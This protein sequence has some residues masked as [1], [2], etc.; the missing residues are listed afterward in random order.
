VQDA[1]VNFTTGTATVLRDELQDA[2]QCVK[3]IESVGYGVV[4]DS[5]TFIPEDGDIAALPLEDIPGVLEVRNVPNGQQVVCFVP[6]LVGRER[7]VDIGRAAGYTATRDQRPRDAHAE[8]YVHAR[9]RFVWATALSLPV[10][11]ISMVPGLGFTGR[12]MLLCALTTP[13][14]VWAGRDFFVLAEKALRHAAAD[15]NTL[16]ALG[17]GA[18]YLYSLVATFVPSWIMQSGMAPEVYFEAAAVIVALILLGR[19]LEMRARARTQAALEA[20]MDLQPAVAHVISDGQVVDMPVSAVRVGDRVMIRPGD[21]VPVDGI[22]EE[23]TSAVNESMITGEPLP[24]EK[25]KGHA[26]L[27]GT[28]NTHGALVVRISHIGERTTLQQI[29]R[30]T[31]EA[32]ERKAPAQ[33]LADKV[34]SIFVP[35][36]LGV[37]TIT[38]AAWIVW[39]SE[40]SRALVAFV[41]VLIIAC[42]CAL[43][44]ATP[45]A[46]VVSTG[47]AARRGMHFKGGDTLQRLSAIRQVVMDKTGTITE[48]KPAVVALGT[49]NE[50][51]EETL[52]RLVASAEVRSQHP[53]GKAIVREAK[54]RGLD[55]HPVSSFVSATGLGITA[56]VDRH[57]ILVGNAPYLAQ[58][59]VFVDA[60]ERAEVL[61]AIDGV[62][63]GS[64]QIRDRTRLSAPSA[65]AALEALDLETTMVTG[66]TEA[67]ARLVAQEVGITHLAAGVLPGGKAQIVRGLQASK[68][69]ALMVG[70]GINDAPALA[71]AAVGIALGTGTQVAMET[72]DITLMR[73]DLHAVAEAVKLSRRTMRVIRQNLFFA[74]A[75]N[76]VS[77]PIA[78]GALYGVLGV[79]LNPMIAS[80]AMAASSVS[81][82][83]NSLRLRRFG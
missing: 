54:R 30:L 9:R 22:V 23:G 63:A 43:G 4:S 13:V 74:F 55:L 64:I 27:S 25:T 26:V 28:V 78:A 21:G 59:G 40:P 47:V 67:S 80:A 53:V 36:V 24:V 20:L 65:V 72:A 69:D 16:V 48:G 19:L 1:R 46:I 70:D 66:D 2:I 39:A 31:R 83:A 79:M 71:E 34:C 33:Q 51:E 41:S 5:I 57:D 81:V 58:H 62:P 75:Y 29:V 52:L 42:P 38:L 8:A 18:A 11:V 77:I 7:L 49:V 14:V 56:R 12:N 35:V 45:T 37:A 76:V 82:V 6:G 68:G 3:A 10:L 61:V 32:Q 44:L 15:M 50:W 60:S 73:D 17:V